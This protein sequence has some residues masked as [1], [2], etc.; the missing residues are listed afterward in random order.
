MASANW[1]D[2]QLALLFAGEV[3]HHPGRSG[4]EVDEKDCGLFTGQIGLERIFTK[5][6]V[7]EQ[8]PTH[9]MALK[10]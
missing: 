1:E 3:G 4:L 2:H 7:G 6:G 8:S 10:R 9:T 5:F